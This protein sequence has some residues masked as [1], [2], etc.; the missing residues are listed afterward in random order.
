MDV[1]IEDLQD[2]VDRA[3]LHRLTV[4]DERQEFLKRGSSQGRAPSYCSEIG[5]STPTWLVGSFACWL[6]VEK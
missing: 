3:R 5:Q 2:G 6:L 1:A 4:H